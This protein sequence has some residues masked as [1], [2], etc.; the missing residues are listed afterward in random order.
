VAVVPGPQDA[1]HGAAVHQ[2]QNAD[3]AAARLQ[4][5]PWLRSGAGGPPS[6]LPPLLQPLL[7]GRL[8]RS[9]T[10]ARTG[11]TSGGGSSCDPCS[12]ALCFFLLLL[13]LIVRCRRLAADGSTGTTQERQMLRR[14]RRSGDPGGQR[15]G[16]Y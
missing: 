15:L 8:L 11:S 9:R 6:L 7:P 4:L 13:L 16:S 3:D 5:L 2:L 12:P 14:L 10:V 1:D